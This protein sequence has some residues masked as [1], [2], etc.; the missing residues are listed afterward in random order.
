MVFSNNFETNITLSK[1]FYPNET[2][3][4]ETKFFQKKVV[5]KS[6]IATPRLRFDLLMYQCNW[7]IDST[8]LKLIY[9]NDNEDSQYFFLDTLKYLIDYYFEPKRIKLNGNIFGKEA[10]FNEDFEYQVQDN[11]IVLIK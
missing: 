8:G 3:Y 4:F 9:I 2:F 6:L 11:K 5:L 7:K 10:I 1:K